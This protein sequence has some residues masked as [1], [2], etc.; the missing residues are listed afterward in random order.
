MLINLK[1]LNFEQLEEFFTS[2][3][4]SK[5]RAKQLF[6][7]IYKKRIN[8]FDNMSDLSLKLR[9][10]LKKNAY[11][12]QLKLIEHKVGAGLAPAR[13]ADTEKYLFELEDGN[14][15]EAVLMKYEEDLGVG[16]LTVCISTQVGCPLDCSFCA[17]GKSGFIRNLEFYEIVDQVL[18][19]ESTL[20][21]NIER[22]GNVVLMGMGE[23]LLNYDNVMKA[24][25]LMNHP[26][27]LSIGARHIAISTAGIV[28][29]ILKLADEDIQFKLAVSLHS[30]DDEKRSKI[31]PVNKKYSLKKLIEAVK[32]YQKKSGRR[33]LFEYALIK[34]FN[35]S[36]EDIIKLRDLVKDISCMIN[37]IPVNPVR[38]SLSNGVN[39]IK[40]GMSMQPPSSAEVKKIKQMMEDC[41][42]KVTVRKSRGQDIDGACGQLRGRIQKTE[43]RS[44]NK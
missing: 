9:E 40:H 14:L 2:I 25:R 44:P 26:E 42:L 37:I 12:S 38:C 23:P 21:S 22:I 27:G 13:T 39:V 10:K 41:G 24:V 8:S 43:D 30:A 36:P 35:D 29:G 6:K 32:K 3:G 7:W 31:M 18:Y 20:D 34:D 11:I 17:T 19:I 4:E 33:V 28:P 5:Y 1:Q 15:I 16:R